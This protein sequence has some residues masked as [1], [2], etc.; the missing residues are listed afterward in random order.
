MT[1]KKREADWQDSAKWK[2]LLPIC[3]MLTVCVAALVLGVISMLQFTLPEMAFAQQEG[4][5]ELCELSYDAKEQIFS[6]ENRQRVEL[7][8]DTG[9]PLASSLLY[10][11]YRQLSDCD[12]RLFVHELQEGSAHSLVYR[13]LVYYSGCFYLAGEGRDG[14]YL[15]Y[16]DGDFPASSQQPIPLKEF[17]SQAFWFQLYGLSGGNGLYSVF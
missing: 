5:W 14:W 11:R 8:P 10:G 6:L 15:T 17:C 2:L 13:G 9:A 16:W 3:A 12:A 1:W 4:S 7:S